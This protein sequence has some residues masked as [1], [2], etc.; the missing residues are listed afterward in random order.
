MP[1]VDVGS[2]LGRWLMSGFVEDFQVGRVKMECCREDEKYG[3]NRV[4]WRKFWDQFGT[5][6]YMV[7]KSDITDRNTE[8]WIK[9]LRLYP[10]FNLIIK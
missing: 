10:Y 2:V 5:T 4:F 8:S 7:A 3:K 6:F 9:E 1:L